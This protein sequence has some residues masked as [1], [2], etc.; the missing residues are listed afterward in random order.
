M[1]CELNAA[2]LHGPAIYSTPLEEKSAVEKYATSRPLSIHTLSKMWNQ[3]SC[4]PN[5][6]HYRG[7]K[8]IYSDPPPPP[9]FEFHLTP[10]E[11]PPAKMFSV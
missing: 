6:G 5:S 4:A 8:G 1:Y 10:S 11:C 9:I 2:T 7:T 3:A